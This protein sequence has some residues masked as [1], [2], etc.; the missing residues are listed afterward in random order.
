M[1]D[2]NIS[3]RYANALLELS[4]EKKIFDKVSEDAEF[5]FNTFFSS[6]ELRKILANP[7]IESAK[8]KSIIEEVFLN[9]ISSETMSF[10]LFVVNKGRENYIYSIMKRFMELRDKKLGYVNIEIS[11]ASELTEEQKKELTDKLKNYT[12]K[13]VR[14]KYKIDS[15]IL[16]GFVARIGDTIMDASILQ[17]LKSLREKFSEDYSLIN[18]N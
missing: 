7:V 17:Q 13:Q 8:K 11:S 4:V 3:T 15:S 14:L 16:G 12:G 10:I 9:K 2:F 18:L 6:K 1:S 5:I